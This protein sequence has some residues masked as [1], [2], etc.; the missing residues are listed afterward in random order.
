MR[1]V[2]E[3]CFPDARANKFVSTGRHSSRN[4]GAIAQ[5]RQIDFQCRATTLTFGRPSISVGIDADSLPHDNRTRYCTTRRRGPL[6]RPWTAR[7]LR[8]RRPDRGIARRPTAFLR[9]RLRSSYLEAI[10]QFAG[11]SSPRS[12]NEAISYMIARS[13]LLKFVSYATTPCRLLHP[14]EYFNFIIPGHSLCAH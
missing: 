10:R 6:P 11:N 1:I 2:D 5:S 4:L 12:D 3:R 8:G 13:A 14:A 7:R 9:E